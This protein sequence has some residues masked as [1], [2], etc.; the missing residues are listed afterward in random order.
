VVVG[1]F[2]DVAW[3][4]TTRLFQRLGRLL[5]ARAGRG[6][7]N[8]FHA[9]HPVM[10]YPPDHVFHT[11][12][13][14]VAGLERLPGFGSDHFPMFAALVFQPEAATPPCGTPDPEG[15]DRQEAE[16]AIRQAAAEKVG[17]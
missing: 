13:F 12:H 16:Q 7:F 8:T 17:R 9:Q 10:R 2:N 4:H 3:S 6:L 15:D 1:G 14:T 5:D 11:G